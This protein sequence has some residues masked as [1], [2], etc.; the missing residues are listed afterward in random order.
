MFKSWKKNVNIWKKDVKWGWEQI[1]YYWDFWSKH[2]IFR[3]FQIL[4]SKKSRC[5]DSNNF[6]GQ[7]ELYEWYNASYHMWY[8][9]KVIIN[10]YFKLHMETIEVKATPKHHAWRIQPR[11]ESRLIDYHIH[12][13]LCPK[14]AQKATL[15]CQLCKIWQQI[16]LQGF[17]IINFGHTRVGDIKEQTYTSTKPH[18]RPTISFS[19]IVSLLSIFD[20]I[21]NQNFIETYRN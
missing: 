7:D 20:T 15:F 12:S 21:G 8:T 5:E 6:E 16:H 13:F 1:L 10:D 18:C 2:A 19:T 14:Y 17:Y 4:D 9:L 3:T 11:H